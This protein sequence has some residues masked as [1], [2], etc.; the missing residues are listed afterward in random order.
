MEK[1]YV[2][3]VKGSGEDEV[4]AADNLETAADMVV[5]YKE[6]FCYDIVD[7]N[8]VLQEMKNRKD[9]AYDYID[10]DIFVMGF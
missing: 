8:E 5:K 7:Y 10:D 9:C 6:E 1:K 4:W 3:V 2:W